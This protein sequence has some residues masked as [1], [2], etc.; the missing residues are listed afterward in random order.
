MR[1]MRPWTIVGDDN[2]SAPH[3]YTK[4]MNSFLS[5]LALLLLAQI[6]LLLKLWLDYRA[7]LNS[8]RYELHKRQL[9]LFPPLA[10]Q[11]DVVHQS[12]S[13]IGTTF[14]GI[15]S[16]GDD[17]TKRFARDFTSKAMKDNLKLAE[18][19]CQAELLLPAVVVI[20]LHQYIQDGAHM[21]SA[22]FGMRAPNSDL[23]TEPGASWRKQQERFDIALNLMRLS[24]GT[25]V[26]TDEFLREAHA[27]HKAT[28]IGTSGVFESI[29]Q[30]TSGA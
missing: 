6:P 11:L 18:L 28:A 17:E 13:I 4:L 3:A 26:L 9:D 12:M 20:A 24:V 16:W 29:A 8:F 10:A 25:D 19:Y 14:D 5:S 27:N 21:M 7:K 22:V 23:P 1:M 30:N 2:Q 15:S